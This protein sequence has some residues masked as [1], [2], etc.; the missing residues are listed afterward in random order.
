MAVFQGCVT[1]VTIGDIA[2]RINRRRI[3][4]SS[5]GRA[6]YASRAA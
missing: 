2:A 1:A 4:P 5:P 3:W 6:P